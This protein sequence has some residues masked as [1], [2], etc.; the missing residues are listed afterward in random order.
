MAGPVYL[1]AEER[2]DGPRVESALD[3]TPLFGTWYNSDY[4]ES[5]GIHRIE[6]S[7]RDGTLR[8]QVFAAGATHPHDWGEATAFAYAESVSD[9]S[10]WAFNVKYDLGFVEVLLSAYTKMFARTGVLAVTSYNTFHD[11]SGR[12]NYW[13]R[14]FYHR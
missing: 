7:E 2:L 9:R 11:D 13:T 3:L 12:A 4:G 14:E 10:A 6:L 1:R 8:V 5:G